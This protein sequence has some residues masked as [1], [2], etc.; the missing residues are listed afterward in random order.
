[1]KSAD[2]A[3]FSHF[4]GS[5]AVSALSATVRGCKVKRHNAVFIGEIE[6]SQ[7]QAVSAGND[8][9]RYLQGAVPDLQED[10]LSP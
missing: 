3:I 7:F 1:V 2:Q 10:V 5:F 8:V 6:I 4:G 9:L